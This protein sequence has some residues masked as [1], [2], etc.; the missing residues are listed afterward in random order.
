MLQSYKRNTLQKEQQISAEVMKHY[1]EMSIYRE[2]FPF[3]NYPFNHIEGCH[4]Q[5]PFF[6]INFHL[7]NRLEDAEEYLER[8]ATIPEKIDQTITFNQFRQD[9][10][11]YTPPLIML[12]VMQ[13][14]IDIFM[15]RGLESN[16]LYEDFS[17]KI[18]RLE[19]IPYEP[20]GEMKYKLR[21]EIEDAVLPA[22]QRLREH[23]ETLKTNSSEYISTKSYSHDY[24]NYLL[25]EHLGTDIERISHDLAP[26]TLDILLN[27]ALKKYQK[28]AK[29]HFSALGY[30]CED[31]AD[32]VKAMQKNPNYYYRDDSYG[33]INFLNDLNLM[34]Y[35]AAK[36]IK[37]L[38]GISTNIS[39]EAKRLLDIQEPF[40]TPFHYFP[41]SLDKQ[42]AGELFVRI[43]DLNELPK[44][45][46][47]A[48]SLEF[49][50]MGSH[51]QN[52]LVIESKLPSL[53]KI[54]QYTYYNEGWRYFAKDWA[55][56][57]K[58]YDD[59]KIALMTSLSNVMLITHALMDIG[60]H[61]YEW[62]YDKAELF[63]MNTIG[64]SK[65]LAKAYVLESLAF[66]A[67]APATFYGKLGFE[68][69]QFKVKVA[70]DEK[71]NEPH[72]FRYLMSN[73]AVPLKIFEKNI[74][75]YIQLQTPTKEKK[76]VFAI[77][78]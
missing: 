65:S 57:N 61:H 49:A 43:E 58:V 19:N 70:L 26:D 35:D 52:S 76:Q 34:N 60:V 40:F 23:I 17:K 24:Y 42:R 56:D 14:Q 6:L 47:P 69:A 77:S 22:Y 53:R 20:L 72:F 44:F 73:G 18:T 25:S 29:N 5:L 3:H 46:L 36:K 67:K 10:M 28:E 16:I 41:A 1:F 75:N 64:I 21:R 11:S 33:R 68:K 54:I 66:P 2:Q 71:Y 48:Y 55:I 45:G 31:L 30:D 32:C 12:E 74:D 50:Y 51:L 62:G 7:I 38:T 15:G 4:V 63:M 27:Q 13:E 78:K 37:L 39:L 59:R 8:L 9:S